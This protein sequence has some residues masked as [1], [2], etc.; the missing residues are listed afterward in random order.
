MKSF[1]KYS[2]DDTTVQRLF[3]TAGFQHV[4]AVEPLTAGEFNSAYC[5]TADGSDYVLKVAPQSGNAHTLTYE[6]DLMRQEVEF[7]CRIAEQTTVRVPKLYYSDFSKEQIPAAFFIMEK[8]SGKPL[9]EV[10]LSKAE[11]DAVYEKVGEMIAELH[12]IGGERFGYVQ[13][14]LCENWYLAA[15]KMVGNLLNDC[16]KAGKRCKAGE[17]LLLC[18]DRHQDIL[19]TVPCVYTH[20]DIWDGNLF[21]E[22]RNGEVQLTLIDA[23]RSF[24]G[25]GIGDFCSLDFFKPLTEKKNLL[26]GYNRKAK[27]PVTGTE[28]EEIRYAVLSG[29]LGLIL[30]TER[31]YRYRKTQMKF[32]FN[33]I[34]ARLLIQK[35]LKVLKGGS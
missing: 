15:R 14:G 4:A 28:A 18:I 32:W 13:N 2:L 29:Y 21:F 27:T 31:F 34:G 19:R 11:H 5:V 9:S 22:R 24:W 8:L 33:G 16:K 26:K 25:D 35:A 10:K 6:T 20:F 3:H 1:T 12:T 30:Y 7:Y 17:E 23:E